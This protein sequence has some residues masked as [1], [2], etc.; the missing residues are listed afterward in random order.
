MNPLCPKSQQICFACAEPCKAPEINPAATALPDEQE[1]P[2]RGILAT[3]GKITDVVGLESTD[4][5]GV[6]PA[7]D[8]IT[9]SI[10][11]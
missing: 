11:L 7:T 5:D 4:D 9:L 3:V 8:K 10:K 1:T 6:T 2:F